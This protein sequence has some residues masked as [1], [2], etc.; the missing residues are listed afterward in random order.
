MSIESTK[1]I[2][3]RVRARQKAES[4]GRLLESAV[5]VFARRGILASTTAEVAMAAGLSQGSL[6]AHFGSQEALVAAAIEEFGEGL[7]RRLHEL[8]AAGA[9]TRAVLEAHLRGLAEREGFY[10]R[11]VVE[12]PLLPP[13]ARDSLVAIQ[14][15]IAFHLAPAVEADTRGGRLRPMPLHLLFNT[16]IG[17]LHHYL[18]N[19]E[20]FAPG[21]SVIERRGR[22]LLDHFMSLIGAPGRRE[23]SER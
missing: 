6:F 9:G 16:W 15:S 14:S 20:L 22:E 3:T 21:A 17:L 18:A 1:I 8:A 19:R 23:G 10:A 11:L 2:R 4:R 12:A 7:A 13:R 5:L